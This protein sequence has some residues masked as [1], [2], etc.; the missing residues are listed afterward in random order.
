M[1]AV[2]VALGALVGGGA[3][4]PPPVSA[5]YCDDYPVLCST[6]TVV[7]EGSGAGSITTADGSISCQ[8]ANGVKSGTCTK[9]FIEDG[10][11]NV[12]ISVTYQASPGS[13]VCE[14]TFLPTCWSQSHT[15]EVTFGSTLT[16]TVT[17]S[18]ADCTA[19]PGSWCHDLVIDTSG[20]GRGTVTTADGH[21]DCTYNAGPTSGSCEHAYWVGPEGG[22]ATVQVS[23]VANTGSVVCEDNAC[24]A[25]QIFTQGFTGTYTLLFEFRL[26][27]YD[28]TVARAGPGTGRIISSPGGIDCGSTC[29]KQYTHGDVVTFAAVADAG[30][31]FSSWSGACAGQDAT[32]DLTVTGASTSTATF[33]KAGSSSAPPVP[34]APPG[35]TPNPAASSGATT[36]PAAS[37][38]PGA[39]APVGAATLEPGASAIAVGS[40]ASPSPA[41]ADATNAPLPAADDASGGS[42]VLLALAIVIAGVL[43]AIGLAVG[44]R[45]RRPGADQPPSVPPPSVEP[46]TG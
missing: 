6:Y 31:T 32:C 20:N 41:T 27:T 35:A 18:P 39:S 33:A 43:I 3:L 38:L 40:G 2:A 7:P 46:P 24:G 45:G 9:R 29:T 15:T 12:T 36:A 14:G 34:T 10:N 8:W 4:Q 11:G 17:F 22:M 44:L 26:R 30:S 1:A 5:A 23:G 25:T 13:Y 21:I 19:V 37:T 42:L 16:Q 28:V